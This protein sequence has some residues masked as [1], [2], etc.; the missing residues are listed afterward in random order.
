MSDIGDH[1]AAIESEDSAEDGS[2]R[3]D[4][5]LISALDVSHVSVRPGDIAQVSIQV[6]NSGEII[7]GITAIVD[8]VDPDWV[9]LERPV[10]SVFPDETAQVEVFFDT[11]A[12]CP[13]GDYLVI[14]RLV[15]TIDPE[16]QTVHDF[17]LT[18]EEVPAL[19][20]DLVPQIVTGG[21]VGRSTA[22]VRNEGNGAANVRISAFDPARGADVVVDPASFFVPLGE[23][24]FVDIRM[25]GKRP[26]FGQPEA[27]QVLVTTKVDDVEVEKTITFNQKPRIPRGLI[28]ILILAGII[29][30]WVLLFWFVMTTVRS[31]DAVGKAPA[32]SFATGQEQFPLK[33]ID[34]SASGTVTAGTTGNGLARLTVEAFRQKA[35]GS[36]DPA[37]SAATIDDGS[38][39]LPSL[40]PGTYAFRVTGDGFTEIWYPSAGGADT[41]E[42]VEL[43]PNETAS[44]I[45]VVVAG[46]TGRIVGTVELPP[47]TP[48]VLLEVKVTQN[49]EG[50]AGS[51]SAADSGSATA[52]AAPELFTV[53]EPVT[54]GTI[55]VD[56]L[57]TP[58]TYTV[59]VTGEGFATLSFEQVV[60]GG[61]VTVV[62]TVNVVAA[63]G[64][65]GGRVI[66]QSGNPVGDVT[67]TIRSGAFAAAATTPTSG[68]TGAFQ[69]LGLVTPATYVITFEAERFSTSTIA[70]EVGPGQNVTGV[71][72][73]VVGGNGTIVGSTISPSGLAIG[74]LAIEVIGAGF[75]QETATLTSTG[76]GG[77]AGSFSMTNIPVPGTY[78][79]TLSGD[80]F[81][82]ETLDAVFMAAGTQLLATVEMVPITAEVSGLV[83]AGGTGVGQ[84]TVTLSSG[85]R[86]FVTLSASSPAGRFAFNGVAQGT[87]TL[88]VEQNGFEPHVV[89][90][91][92]AGG[93]DIVRDISIVA[94]TP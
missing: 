76:T 91:R 59:T 34:V 69:F 32:S 75:R 39:A 94:A 73:T 8:G 26:W 6:T 46:E 19:G 54:D 15:S 90:V 2:V 67:V 40:L 45:D 57:P 49:P 83:L 4:C 87:Y 93:V 3:A 60:D 30:L 22:Q 35:D 7:D 38:F 92:V 44:S 43:A 42:R 80:G 29:A 50:A 55:D 5:D 11:P 77:A 58:A 61:E 68:N 31:Q 84:A 82:T 28:T 37:G 52:G 85:V 74:G 51:G 88:T 16:R 20:V 1:D 89:L 81:Q 86:D 21:K 78:T 17:W 14:A 10:V 47:N 23:S 33:L 9:R 66:D 13:A 24:G 70:L 25:R 36:L 56:G 18:V 71:V 12:N 64:E 41:A 72:G 65:V 48:E 62:N 79:I 63:S 27:R 53:T